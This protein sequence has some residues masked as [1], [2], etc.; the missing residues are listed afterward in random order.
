MKRKLASLGI[1]IITIISYMHCGPDVFFTHPQPEHRRNM[2]TIP[3]QFLGKF[4]STEDSSIFQIQNNTIIRVWSELAKVSR[5][6]I[7]KEL[8]T[9]ITES[10]I[11]YTDSNMVFD[12]QV[13]GDSALV[14]ATQTDTIFMLQNE[15]LLRKFNGYFFLNQYIEKN[16]WRVM[17]MR[18]N[19]DTLEFCH[20]VQSSVIDSIRNFVE[21]EETQDTIS[22]KIEYYTLHADNKQLKAI[23]KKY[24]MPEKYIKLNE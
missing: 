7:S 16:K 18:L 10:F 3:D 14:T 12:I 11:L 1:F 20:A 24:L 15:N 17:L 4:R 8:D 22:G 19:N 9:Q 6:E 21:V 5:E 13:I 23:M 2:A